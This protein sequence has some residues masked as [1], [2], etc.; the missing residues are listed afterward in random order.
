MFAL[1]CDGIGIACMPLFTGNREAS[2]LKI[3]LEDY[4]QPEYGVYA[5]YPQR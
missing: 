3:L 4:K 1:V 5:V 2:G